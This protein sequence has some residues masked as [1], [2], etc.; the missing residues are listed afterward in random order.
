MINKLKTLAFKIYTVFLLGV[1]GIAST[2]LACFAEVANNSICDYPSRGVQNCDYQ[3]YMSVH[4]ITNLYA[5]SSLSGIIQSQHAQITDKD[6][7]ISGTDNFSQSTGDKKN[8]VIHILSLLDDIGREDFEIC[9]A[10]LPQQKLKKWHI[11]KTYSAFMKNNYGKIS[12][13][14]E[15][16][17]Q[18]GE[19]NCESFFDLIFGN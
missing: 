19:E 15:I 12:S 16:N 11:V 3:I 9:A 5:S 10:L 14:G 4:E 13:S 17:F 8:D 7:K 6:K 2:N 1:L 18:I